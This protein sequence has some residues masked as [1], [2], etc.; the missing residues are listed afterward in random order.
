VRRVYRSFGQMASAGLVVTLSLSFFGDVPTGATSAP[1]SSLRCGA[2][3]LT[4]I[5]RGTT[6]G[7]AGT[8]GDLFWIR[9]AGGFSCVIS[10]YPTIVF[11]KSGKRVDLKATDYLGQMG[12]DQ[13]GV[14]KGHR[15]PTVRL[16]PN[17]GVASFWVFGT[18]VMSPCPNPSQLVVSL[19]SLSGRVVIPTPSGFQWWPYC[20]RGFAVNPIV[21]GISG[22]DP[23]RPLH[24][25]IMR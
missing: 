2:D 3:A 19:K 18:D 25:E 15:P 6:G 1:A 16:A 4:V 13:M 12:N 14:T 21:P 9:N 23:A 8:F 22:S 20:G 24:T 10:G 7:L 17:G 5:W 11:Y